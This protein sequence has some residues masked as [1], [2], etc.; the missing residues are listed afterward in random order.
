MASMD[1]VLLME[2]ELLFD[3]FPL[4]PAQKIISVSVSLV[5]TVMKQRK[6]LSVQVN[7]LNG[8]REE[9]IHLHEKR[10]SLTYHTE[11]KRKE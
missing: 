8:E 5:Q 7:T 3:N 9:P 11:L 4:S 2:P 1:G 6:W 10:N